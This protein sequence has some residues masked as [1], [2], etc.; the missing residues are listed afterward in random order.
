MSNIGK[1]KHQLR[2]LG[3]SIRADEAPIGGSRLPTGR[4]RASWL[5]RARGCQTGRQR[6]MSMATKIAVAW[7]WVAPVKARASLSQRRNTN[8]VKR[9]QCPGGGRL[10]SRA[11]GL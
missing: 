7:S 11:C 2:I 4:L 6:A 9:A 10:Q 1:Q 5:H 3:A 8:L